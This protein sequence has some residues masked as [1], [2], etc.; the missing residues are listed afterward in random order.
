[1]HLAQCQP[2]AHRMNPRGGRGA[3]G[4]RRAPAR[5]PRSAIGLSQRTNRATA[6]SVGLRSL[7]A[8]DASLYILDSM[9]EKH[10]TVAATDLR[11]HGSD[12]VNRVAFGREEIVLTRR[13]KPVA[14]L[15]PVETLAALKRLEDRDDLVAGEAA[16]ED[17]REHGTVPLADVKA[18]YGV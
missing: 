3:R 15:V 7:D 12:I 4:R 2:F 11:Q 8:G 14:A 9:D 5:R 13:G 6:W 1:V 17:A 16:L 18:R 10:T